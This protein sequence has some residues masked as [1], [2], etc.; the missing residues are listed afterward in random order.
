MSFVV[1]FCHG[2]NRVNLWLQHFGLYSTKFPLTLNHTVKS[3]FPRSTWQIW[4]RNIGKYCTSNFPPL[5]CVWG[6]RCVRNFSVAFP[7]FCLQIYV[8]FLFQTVFS[9]KFECVS[10]TI[11][12][13]IYWDIL[14]YH[15]QRCLIDCVDYNPQIVAW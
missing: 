15:W 3:N 14:M 13:Y 11:H 4:Q 8:C 6:C 12:K 1:K 7:M 2:N 10:W 9:V 5:C